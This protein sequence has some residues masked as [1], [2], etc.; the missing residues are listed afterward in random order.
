MS[1]AGKQRSSSVRDKSQSPVEREDLWE[2]ESL[3]P[4]LQQAFKLRLE[5]RLKELE[6]LDAGLQDSVELDQSRVGRL[7]RVDAL[8]IKAME[9]ASARRRSEERRRI[10]G[11]LGRIEEGDYGLCIDCEELIPLG[12]LEIDP[13]LPRCVLC[14]D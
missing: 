8:Q 10:Y 1:S 3:E 13:S 7:S 11:A 9:V 6:R 5:H 12:R 2:E 14:A 4:A